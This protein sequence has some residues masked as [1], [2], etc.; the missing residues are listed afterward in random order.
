MLTRLFPDQIQ[1]GLAQAAISTVVALAVVWLARQRSI[2]LGR[3]TIVALFRG[4]VQVVVVGLVLVVALNGPLLVAAL[5]LLVMMAAAAST[6]ARRG[7]RIPGV[8]WVALAGIA[9]GSGILIL[10]MT[11]LGVI[12]PTVSSVVTVGSMI[13]ANSMNSIAL[14]LDRFRAEVETHV[15]HIE[16]ALAL[17]AE[18]SAV[19]EPYIQRATH[20]AM[21]PRI[22]NLRS[23]G[24]V[25][26]P[27]LMA[28][29]IISG[30]SPVYAGIYQFVVL[31]L[32]YAAGG[33][34]TVVS[35][36]LIRHRVFSPADQLILRPLAELPRGR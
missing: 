7:S 22:D 34:T 31:A 2:F 30:T 1:L 14:A 32:I 29:M 19:V 25:W 20:A 6:S 8:L 9:A 17:G 35:L 28:G 33:L 26:I 16:T 18:P 36:L 5:L 24:I 4:L 15:G 11:I 3:E 10:V 27:G 21:I 13:I 12:E 23:L